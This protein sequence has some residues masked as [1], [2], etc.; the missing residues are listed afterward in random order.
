MCVKEYWK[1]IYNCV[2]SLVGEDFM[3][4]CKLRSAY[5]PLHNFALNTNWVTVRPGT[6]HFYNS[7]LEYSV[8]WSQIPEPKLP[9]QIMKY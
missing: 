5:I 8:I 6:V 3:Y 4:S 2:Y 1:F 7:A 9:S